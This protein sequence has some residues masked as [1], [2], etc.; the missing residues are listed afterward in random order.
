MRPCRPL[1]SSAYEALE[2]RRAVRETSLMA[3]RRE[4]ATSAKIPADAVERIQAS[5]RA[6]HRRDIDGAVAPY[7]DE[8][9]WDTR[10]AFPDGRLYKGA[11]AF[12]AYCEEVLDRW[13]NEH[14][15]EIEEILG[16]EGTAT[17][18]VRFRM[19]GRSQSGVPIDTPWVHVLDF[20]RGEIV[21]ARNFGSFD[22][23]MECLGPAKLTPLWQGASD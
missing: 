12:R 19:T 5:N 9:E 22:A 1:G 2:G 21:R 15:L 4:S 14:R 16:V 6:W 18:V 11:D 17:V 10:A 7:S 20:D 3:K 23:A 8:I 13:S